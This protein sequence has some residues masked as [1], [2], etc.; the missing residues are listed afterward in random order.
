MTLR[1]GVEYGR[2]SLIGGAFG[3]PTQTFQHVPGSVDVR[4]LGATLHA[5]GRIAGTS[6]RFRADACAAGGFGEL[7]GW[8]YYETEGEASRP[9]FALGGGL[10]ARGPIVGP[11]GWGLLGSLLAPLAEERFSVTVQGKP[12]VAYATREA[13]F[14]GGLEL[15]VRFL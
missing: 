12:E 10:A 9:W 7:H 3:A 8:G 4:L 2:A 5:C 15:W 11:L 1:V 13:A 6:W 14:F